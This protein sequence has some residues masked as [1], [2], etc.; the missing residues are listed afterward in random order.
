MFV[1]PVLMLCFHQRLCQKKFPFLSCFVVTIPV[2]TRRLMQPQTAGF[3]AHLALNKTSFLC[4][5]GVTQRLRNER[6]KMGWEMSVK[7][8]MRCPFECSVGEFHLNRW[9]NCN[10]IH[11][12]PV[13]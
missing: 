8:R 1:W 5:T 9:L 2:A 4:I 3:K 7:G 11:S 13:R 12:L 6:G 10:L